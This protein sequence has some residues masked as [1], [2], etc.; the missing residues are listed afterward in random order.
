MKITFE[1]DSGNVVVWENI[2]ESKLQNILNIKGCAEYFGLNRNSV[3]ARIARGA[4]VLM[5]LATED[6][7]Q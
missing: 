4:P 7:K 3:A 5:A 1:Q 6:H 2:P